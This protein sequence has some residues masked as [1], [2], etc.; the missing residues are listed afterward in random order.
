MIRGALQHA[1]RRWGGR[2][3]TL[4]GAAASALLVSCGGGTAA[5]TASDRDSGINKTTLSVEVNDADGDALSYQW[6][7]TAGTIDNRNAKEV[8][9]TL[10]DGDGLHFAYVMVSDGRGGYVEQQYAVA[11]D[12]LDTKAPSKAPITRTAPAVTDFDGATTRLRFASA[13]NTLF[14][15][16]AAGAAAEARTVFLPDVQVQVSEQATGTIVYSGTTNTRGELELPKL[17]AGTPY[18]VKCGIG[19]GAPLADCASFNG[20]N[21]ATLRRV[22]PVL[23]AA[24]N[25]RLY[26]HVALDGG[27]LCGMDNEFFQ[28]QSAASV[29]L[30]LAD[31]TALG[32]RV[33]VNRYGDYQVSAGVPVHGALK[34]EVKCE[35]YT[36]TLDVPASGDPAGYVASA[37]I[38]LSHVIANRRPTLVKMVANGPDGNIRGRMVVAGQGA[39]SDRLKGTD[40]FLSYKGLDTKLSAC[41]YYRALGAVGE[42][43]AQGNP[44]GAISFDDWK[45]QNAFGGPTDVAA[46]YVNQRDL[47][48]VRRM[49]ATRSPSGVIA[50]YVCNNPGPDGRTQ[51]EIDDVIADALATQK[52][53]ACVAMEYSTVTGANNNQPFTKFYTF[54]PDGSLLLSINLDGRGE[55]YMPGSC[56]ACHGGTTYNGRF[57]E[58][59]TA[60]PYLGA[61][62]LAFDTGNYL[63]SSQ[64][65]LTEAAQSESIYQLNQLVRAT[66]LSDTSPTSELIKGWYANGHVL[67]KA[68]VPPVWQAEDAVNPGAARFYKELVAISCRTCHAAFDPSLAL[69]WDSTLLTPARAEPQFCGGKADLAVNASMP[70]ALMSSDG[71]LDRINADP[72][73]AALATTYLGCSAPKPDPVYPKKQ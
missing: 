52:R 12:L 21:R 43:D 28:V 31:G 68:W 45:R 14:K 18:L 22:T 72:A 13:D 48:L 34:L 39:G 35:G 54:G 32:S 5:S 20:Q 16:A 23:D 10:P 67:D 33:R 62:F 15:P 24:Q 63:F 6:R 2:V 9:W 60:S 51:K 49:V 19:N 65:L 40:H 41:L 66:E 56:V 8:V 70:Q 71:V 64:P 58:Q 53:V 1:G 47:N 59:Q 17:A 46:D 55:K 44:T 73:L 3:A 36:A 11:T 37:P 29:Q 61:R 57:P 69:D 30:R 27:D 4:V 38:E 7:V 26:G 25:L 42:C 50:F